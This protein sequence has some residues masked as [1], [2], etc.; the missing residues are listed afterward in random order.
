[1]IS[2]LLASSAADRAAGGLDLG[3]RAR[4]SSAATPGTVALPLVEPLTISLPPMTASV[5]AYDDS[6]IPSNAFCIVSVR[7]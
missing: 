1:M 6:K 7:M 4:P 3:Q 5:S 2:D